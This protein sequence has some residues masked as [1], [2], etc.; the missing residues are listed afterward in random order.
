MDVAKFGVIGAG[1]AGNFH[2]LAFKGKTDAK[3]QYVAVCDIDEKTVNKFAKRLKIE[4][5]TDIDT[6]LQQDLDAV[7]VAV[8]HFLH[9]EIVKRVAEAGKNVIC[10]KPMATTLEECDEMISATKKAGVKFMIA[11][12]HRFLPAHRKIKEMLDAGFL[13]DVYLGRTYE[14]A[15]V[16]MKHFLDANNW[17]FTYERGGGGVLADQGVHK[18]ALLEY[19]LGDVE[20]GEAWLSKVFNSPESKGEDNAMMN[21][22]FKNGAMVN[23]IVSSTTVHPLNNDTELH[24]TKGHILE[25]HSWEKPIKVFS[26]SPDA[27]KKGEYYEV[28]CEH[29]AYPAYYLISAFH[30]DTHFAESIINDTDPEFTPEQAKEAVAT[31]LLGYL[32]AK[33]GRRTTMEELKSHAESQGTKDL[34]EGL[35]EVTQQNYE[36][37]K[38]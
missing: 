11:E 27:E 38:W 33:N 17:Q 10:E 2:T 37:V 3:V 8:P 18:F 32:S 35:Q 12:N 30:E 6:F 1:D 20:S 15:F 9:A 5:F 31:V 4:P 24:G 21:L 13:G 16:P 14:G 28:A 34:L 29:G 7:L 23:V 19:L 25:N 22:H 36:T 26:N